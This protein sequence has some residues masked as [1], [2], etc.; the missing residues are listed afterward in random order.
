M[1]ADADGASIETGG[2]DCDDS[3][4][5]VYPGP[6]SDSE[7]ACMRD[8]DED[9]WGDQSPPSGV[10]AGSDCDDEDDLT[11]PA[12]RPRRTRLRRER[13]EDGWGDQDVPSGIDGAKTHDEDDLI[14]PGAAGRSWPPARGR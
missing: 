14:F 6:R 3:D 11:H 12:A 9:D 5:Q 7:T 13:D 1:D 10:E 2:E 8:A 4:A